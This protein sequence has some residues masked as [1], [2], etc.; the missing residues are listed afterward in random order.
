[1]GLI[2]RSAR[3]V[4]AWLGES[5]SRSDWAMKTLSEFGRH[6]LRSM[7]QLVS[8]DGEFRSTLRYLLNMKYWTRVWIIQEL[9]LPPSIEIWCGFRTVRLAIIHELQQ[10]ICVHPALQNTIGSRIL[11]Q[12]FEHQ[13]RK[14]DLLH[15]LIENQ[16]AEC[17]VI[18]DKV[19]GMLS[20]AQDADV[21]QSLHVDY[22]KPVRHLLEQLVAVCKVPASDTFRFAHFFKSMLGMSSQQ[23]TTKTTR[24]L[25]NRY[26]Q[27]PKRSGSR[28]S[29]AS[30]STYRS[31]AMKTATAFSVGRILSSVNHV[32]GNPVGSNL[33]RGFEQDQSDGLEASSDPA[34]THPDIHADTIARLRVAWAWADS[35][36]REATNSSVPGT[37]RHLNQNA[38]L[39]H[40]KIQQSVPNSHPKRLSIGIAFGHVTPYDEIVQFPGFDLALVVRSSPSD[41]ISP[42]DICGVL[43]HTPENDPESGST[44]R[45]SVTGSAFQ[46]LIIESSAETA[47][48]NRRLHVELS[49]SEL[50]ELV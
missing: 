47:K 13:A 25:D 7:K 30:S 19:Y 33:A 16:A 12:R 3:K 6:D 39:S 18:Q 42:R 41:A 37:K 32:E 34:S 15:L 38:R 48:P 27:T 17:S 22:S 45:D 23:T 2:Y 4:I 50:I 20:L 44:F 28:Q 46:Y 43:F 35:L 36:T 49:V 5:S 11:T 29:L 14:Q 21:V 31:E 40:V 24:F 1:M 10:A 8:D 9:M 26:R